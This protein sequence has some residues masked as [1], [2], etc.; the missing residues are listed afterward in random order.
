MAQQDFIQLRYSFKEHQS[1][2]LSIFLKD[3]KEVEK[4]KA[5]HPNFLFLDTI[6]K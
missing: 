3:Q 4:Y 2:T 1:I 6:K 5:E